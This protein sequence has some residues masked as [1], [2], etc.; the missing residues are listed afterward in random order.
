SP[1][2]PH[3]PLASLGRARGARGDSSSSRTPAS[4]KWRSSRGGPRPPGAAPWPSASKR[5][6]SFRFATR[7]LLAPR[8]HNGTA[9]SRY[10]AHRGEDVRT[11]KT[12]TI[13]AALATVAT[14]AR[15][16]T[17]VAMTARAHARARHGAVPPLDQPAHGRDA[18]RADARRTR[19]RRPRPPPA[20]AAREPAQDHQA[21]RRR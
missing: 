9:L 16:T 14:G 20:R 10:A 8:L 13:A 3:S 18:R 5:A 4:P 6:N 12:L 19:R 2:G 11:I 1:P 17:F 21:S 7:P 15:A